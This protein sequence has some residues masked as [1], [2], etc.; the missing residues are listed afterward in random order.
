MK[1]RAELLVSC[2][3]L[4]ICAGLTSSAGAAELVTKA[5]VAAPVQWWYEGFAE[6]GGRFNIQASDRTELGKFYRYEDLRPGVFG[7]FLF[8][9]HRN[10]PD[11]LDIEAWGKNV[12]WDDQ[13]FGLDIAKPG[14]YY[15]TFG[16][17]ET[18]HVWSQKA[19]SI[20]SGVG[21]NNLT[22]NVFTP[23]PAVA[24]NAANAAIIANGANTI[25]LKIRRDTA[26]AAARW[27]PNDNW[28]FAADYSHM[29]RSGVQS[30]G[31]VSFSGTAS[32]R[33]TFEVPKP[34][35]DVTQNAKLKGEYAGSTPWGKPFNLAIGGGFSTYTDR[36]NSMTFQN[37]WNPTNTAT[38]PLNNQYSLWPDNQAGSVSVQGGV[39][40]PLNSRY[41][42][43]FQYTRMTADASNLPFTVN[44]LVVLVPGFSNQ[45]PDRQTETIL[46]NN[47]LNTQITQDLTST[48]KYRYYNYNAQN[49]PAT[50]TNFPP[51]P[52]SNSGNPDDENMIRFPTDYT[53]QN[54]DAQLVWKATKYLN[55][56]ASYDWEGW[57]RSYRAVN[58]TNENSGKVFLDSKW[59]FSTL[60][61]SLLYGQRRNSGYSDVADEINDT[62]NNAA[63]RM[64]D[65]ANRDRTKGQISWAVDVSDTLTVTP[66]GG[67]LYDDYRTDICF[68]APGCQAGM[69]KANSWNAGAD[70]MVNLN[71]MVALMFSY[72]YDRGYRQVYENSAVPTLNI[73]TADQNHTFII[74]GKFTLIPGKLFL[75]ANF[76]HTFS[77][78]QWTSSCTPAG[79]LIAA[80]NPLPIFPDTHN[81]NDRLD[82]QAKYMFD[83]AAT[84]GWGLWPKSQAYVKARVLWERNSNDAWQPLQV[85]SGF[86][87]PGGSTNATTTNSFWMATGNPNYSVVLGQLA[88]G[89]KW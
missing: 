48:L 21:G 54:A 78:S 83:E 42:G 85:Q 75:D 53:K 49:T 1:V 62:A 39:G 43:T 71:R 52:D 27:T 40:L 72:N 66:N 34:V 29:Q 31:M 61:A 12:G 8:G 56:G 30:Q 63:F 73:E 65:L 68:T 25:D 51:N 69:K 64:R 16:W 22:V 13:A 82:V 4:V 23:A 14:T 7:N 37:P 58:T 50:V 67:F 84:R 9:A 76:A 41:M 36:W 28:D 55:L 79:C 15:L 24:P 20:W 2:A 10:G 5:P 18:P 19:R 6:V 33:T 59:G 74:G 47:V 45:M 17:D 11:P 87:I 60:R 57:N 77:V 44:P 80:P 86:A 38:R 32:T 26:S 35:D 46:F 3:A 70:A 89:V 88:F 81:T